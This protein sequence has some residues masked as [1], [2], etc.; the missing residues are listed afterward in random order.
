M[1]NKI[2]IIEDEEALAKALKESL[3]ENGFEVEIAE[4][5]E[6]GIKK[7]MSLK[8]D[9]VLLD[10]SLEGNED[11]LDLVRWMRKSE[12]WKKTPVIATTAHAFT[13]DQNNCLAAGCND[14]LSKPIK[15]EK[16][17]EKISAYI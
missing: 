5:G 12:N 14:Y 9:L 4:D 7:I 8:P 11:G 15:R 1:K 3:V 6:E 17:L 16:L 13:T 10:L 2:L